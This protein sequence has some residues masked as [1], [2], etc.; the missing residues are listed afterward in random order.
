MSNRKTMHLSCSLRPSICEAV[1]QTDRYIYPAICLQDFTIHYVILAPFHFNKLHACGTHSILNF[2]K[3]VQSHN[4]STLYIGYTHCLHIYTR[5][6]PAAI[7]YIPLLGTIC[8]PRGGH[9]TPTNAKNCRLG[10]ENLAKLLILM[11]QVEAKCKANVFSCF[12]LAQD[13]KSQFLEIRS[14]F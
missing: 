4:L 3:N 5:G 11:M 8:L 10:P 6:S 9:P 13:I 12:C 1:I 14:Q 7:Y 2:S